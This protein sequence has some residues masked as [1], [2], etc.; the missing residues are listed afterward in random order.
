MEITSSFKLFP[1]D[2]LTA[3]RGRGSSFSL[4]RR[5]ACL[6]I[7]TT[8]SG[9]PHSSGRGTLSACGN[10]AQ[11]LQKSPFHRPQ[12]GSRKAVVA[13]LRRIELDKAACPTHAIIFSRVSTAGNYASV[14]DAGDITSQQPSSLL[15]VALRK[16][17]C[18]PKQS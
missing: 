16:V 7:R 2:S 10:I 9:L 17:F 15:D 11:K 4:L 14:F 18:P 3:L 6:T 5:A 1:L 12:D 13:N 8:I